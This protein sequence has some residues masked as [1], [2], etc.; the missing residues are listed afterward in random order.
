MAWPE[1]YVFVL[2]VAFAYVSNTS[3]RINFQEKLVM[4]K[5]VLNQWTTRN[6]TLVRRIC[7][8]KML[9]ISKLVHNASVLTATVPL[10]S[11]EKVN[12]ISLKFI[13]NFKPGKVKGQPII[14]PVD[15]GGLNMVDFTMVV[16]SIKAVWVKRL[17][18][19]D[20]SKWCSLFSSVTSQYGGRVIF[21]CNFDICDLN[22]TSHVPKFYRDI[23]TVWQE[24]HSKNPSTGNDYQHESIWNNHF[25]RIDGKPVF[26]LSWYRKGVF[27]IHHLLNESR[28][29]L[30]RSDFE[31]KYGLCFY[32]TSCLA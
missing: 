5:K 12:D 24:L 11:A 22:L 28:N 26:Y 23:L 25:I 8:V 30:S 29:F 3:Y 7:I 18:E 9:A 6:S 32:D 31:Q 21:Y 14:G 10:N 20:G 4:L 19:E 16:K 15:K 27:K 13:W 17:C 2:G 1:E